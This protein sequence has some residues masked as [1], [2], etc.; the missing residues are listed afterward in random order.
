MEQETINALVR[1]MENFKAI[2]KEQPTLIKPSYTNEDVMRIFGI[3]Y[4]TLVKWRRN[5]LIGYSQIGSTFAYSPQDISDFLQKHHW[6]A[7]A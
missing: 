4:P 7:V 3:S 2:L 1:C 6:E 5:G